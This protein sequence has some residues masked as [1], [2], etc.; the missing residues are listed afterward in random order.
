VG[1]TN[2]FFPA[3][4]P[5]NPLPPRALFP[6]SLCPSLSRWQQLCCYNS[7]FI[8]LQYRGH[9]QH[10]RAYL[11]NH[12]EPKPPCFASCNLLLNIC[13]LLVRLDVVYNS[14]VTFVAICVLEIICCAKHTRLVEVAHILTASAEAS[15]RIEALQKLHELLKLNDDALSV[16]T[17]DYG[18]SRLP[19]KT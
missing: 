16:R 9:S 7:A 5:T 18:I 8:F 4:G 3:K 1:D 17:C 13:S 2:C 19:T 12:C 6:R 14:F 10:T 15:T 11:E